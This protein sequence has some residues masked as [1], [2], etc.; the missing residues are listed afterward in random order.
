L[1][2]NLCGHSPYVTF[3]LTRGWVCLLW[4]GFVFVKREIKPSLLVP[5]LWLWVLRSQCSC[6]IGSW[7][8]V[9]MQLSLLLS[10]LTDGW[11]ESTFAVLSLILQSPVIPLNWKLLGEYLCSII[12][13]FTV[14]CY[15]F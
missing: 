8:E 12:S 14:T 7:L 10:V 11:W 2:L 6:W 3:S 9:V 5:R 13:D 15:S 1:Q 4:I